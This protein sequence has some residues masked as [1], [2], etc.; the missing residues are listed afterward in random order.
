[1]SVRP[2]REE[3]RCGERGKLSRGMG[4]I[5]FGRVAAYMAPSSN[6][7]QDWT[8]RCVP[9]AFDR[10]GE[11]NN[12]LELSIYWLTSTVSSRQTRSSVKEI[13]TRYRDHVTAKEG[14]AVFFVFAVRASRRN[15]LVAPSSRPSVA[16]QFG[17]HVIWSDVN[18]VFPRRKYILWA[19]TDSA[20]TVTL[21]NQQVNVYT[22]VHEA[23][24]SL[25]E[26]G[27]CNFSTHGPIAFDSYKDNKLATGDLI[28]V[29]GVTNA[30]VA[31]PLIDFP[32]RRP[33]HQPLAGHGREQ[34]RACSDAEAPCCPVIHQTF[35][36]Q[37]VDRK[38][39]RQAPARRRQSHVSVRRR[40]LGPR[41]VAFTDADRV[42]DIGRV[43][44]RSSWWAFGADIAV[45]R[46][47]AHGKRVAGEASSSEVLEDTP[48]E[49]CAR[50]GPK[51]LNERR[52][53]ADPECGR[54]LVLR[55][56]R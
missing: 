22:S 11:N 3:F 7:R 5:F 45:P 40:P 38:C 55:S 9:N 43:A 56:A 29:D 32:L 31:A 48:L 28:F 37:H 21:L 19:K 18:P 47:K 17:A 50:H 46:Q 6:R 10:W 42:E 8:C 53:P 4:S 51:G 24:I 12:Q 39:T 36:R 26:V 15:T 13:V 2:I 23:A 30:T 49:E 52:L 20:S 27:V 34:R 14:E 1:M 33:R 44:E 54:C 25:S 41:G 35:R 16:G